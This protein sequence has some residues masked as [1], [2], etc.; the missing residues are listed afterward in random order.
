ML[1]LCLNSSIKVALRSTAGYRMLN[2]LLPLKTKTSRLCCSIV[3]NKRESWEGGFNVSKEKLFEELF[4]ELNE[5]EKLAKA[6]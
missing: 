3:P 4:V 1:L 5:V 2:G 6:K